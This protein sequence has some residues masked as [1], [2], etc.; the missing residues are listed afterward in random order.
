MSI[1]ITLY[2]QS[3]LTINAQQRCESLRRQQ[4]Q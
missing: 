3:K 4:T 2:E 1:S